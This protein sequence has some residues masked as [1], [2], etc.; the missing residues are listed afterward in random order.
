MHFAHPRLLRSVVLG[1]LIAGFLGVDFA[2]PLCM[3]GGENLLAYAMLGC[4]IGQINLIAV[5]AALARGNFVVRLPWSLLLGTMMWYALVL[6]NRTTYYVRFSLDEAILL[7]VF[8]L[9]G[10]VVAQIP[11]WIAGKVFGWQLI[12]RDAWA[13][14]VGQGRLQFNL[15]HMLLGTA[16]L[17]IAL[18]PLRKILPLDVRGRS[19]FDGE[20]LVVFAVVAICNLLVTIPCIWG[21]MSRTSRLMLLAVGWIVYCGLLT[22]I[23]VGTVAVVLRGPPLAG[24]LLRAAL[25]LYLFN[26]S[27]CAT[28]F[29]TLLLLRA[30]GFQ[31]VRRPKA[32]RTGP[33]PATPVVSSS[34]DGESTEVKPVNQENP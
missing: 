7:G 18:A 11:L 9:A 3:S 29:G 32:F 20:M 6:G 26:A 21:A 19:G 14:P 30:L 4:C 34:I 2:V 15:Q 25:H 1:I 16:L 23:E 22:A 28:V 13:S 17:S 24:E 33:P 27:Q 31:L 8:L 10:I 12:T 5:W